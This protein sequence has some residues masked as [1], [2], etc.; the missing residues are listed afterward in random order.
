MHIKEI[1]TGV[2]H[3]QVTLWPM[4]SLS[5]R[6]LYNFRSIEI[7]IRNFLTCAMFKEVN[8]KKQYFVKK[9]PAPLWMI[10]ISRK[11]VNK[12]EEFGQ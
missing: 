5:E 4:P 11:I 12:N 9:N 7:L 1:D 8:R 10:F 2:L 6:Y 3:D